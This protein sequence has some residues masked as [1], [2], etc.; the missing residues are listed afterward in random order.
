MADIHSAY[1]AYKFSITAQEE[2][3]KKNAADNQQFLQT[4]ALNSLNLKQDFLA[5]QQTA[6]VEVLKSLN[7]KIDASIKSTT[8]QFYWVIGVA[9]AT[10]I[11]TIGGLIIALIK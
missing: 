7:D 11:A 10:L 3:R 6:Q 5:K 2:A 8:I 4:E 1:S 9:T